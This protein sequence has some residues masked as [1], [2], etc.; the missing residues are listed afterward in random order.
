MVN[1]ENG[2]EVVVYGA[3]G[4]T[5]RFVVAELVR[6]GLRPVVAGRRAGLLSE[7]AARHGDLSVRVAAV[8]DAAGLAATVRGARVVVNAAGP[9]LDTAPALAAASVAAGAHYL[10][11]AAEQAAAR[12][13]LDAH[14]GAG[15]AVVPALAFYGGLPDLLATAAAAGWERVDE[16]T[17]AYG[18][19][20]W[21]P[22]A[23][24]RLTGRRNT[25]PRLVLEDGRLVP[26]PRPAPETSWQFPDPLGRQRVVGNPFTE[27]VLLAR[28]LG[29]AR[30]TSLLTGSALDDL[31][32]TTTP[33]PA[34]L[35]GTGRSAQRFVVEVVTRRGAEERRISASGQDIYAST[36]P[37]VAEGVLRLLDGRTLTTGA[38][39]PGAAFDA[40]DVLTALADDGHLDVRRSWTSPGGG[41]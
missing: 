36:A 12:N 34:A 7:M 39:A 14:A 21:W 28:H 27:V 10:D 9:F 29:V 23:G 16:V 5:G 33:A 26:A 32:D 20:R 8:D 37:L 1:R 11:L 4:H 24:T 18:V 15:V 13:L 35:D 38:R 2:N 25:V 17:V 40:D 6:R 31:R 22:T 3:S 19:D 30:V 41:R